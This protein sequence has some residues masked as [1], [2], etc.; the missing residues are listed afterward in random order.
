M[1]RRRGLRW[2][3]VI[4]DV[5]VDMMTLVMMGLMVVVMDKRW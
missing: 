1:L 5:D 4:V 2:V 3:M